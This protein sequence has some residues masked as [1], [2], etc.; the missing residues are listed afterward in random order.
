MTDRSRTL[1]VAASCLSEPP[2]LPVQPN[3]L[4]DRF[5]AFLVDPDAT[6]PMPKQRDPLRFTRK[7]TVERLQEVKSYIGNKERLAFRYAKLQWLP[8]GYLP[9]DD[10][11]YY[12]APRLEHERI[13]LLGERATVLTAKNWNADRSFRRL[14]AVDFVCW[15]LGGQASI[16]L[17]IDIGFYSYRRHDKVVDDDE[18]VTKFASVWLGTWHHA[19]LL[20]W[21]K[22]KPATINFD[23]LPKYSDLIK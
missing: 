19:P 16:G 22:A 8:E 20:A 11:S 21:R 23:S 6:N 7:E 14:P 17:V 10:E 3:C 1:S 15:D 13:Q 18:K 4:P 9:D 12:S 2:S 5:S